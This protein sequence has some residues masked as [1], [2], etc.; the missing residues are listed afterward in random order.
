[1]G[2]DGYPKDYTGHSAIYSH[3]GGELAFSEKKVEVLT[4]TL[5]A[6]DLQDF[7]SR[8]AFQ[9]DADGFELR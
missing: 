3:S 7:R 1:M 9:E 5:S 4:Q 8:F 2:T 6:K